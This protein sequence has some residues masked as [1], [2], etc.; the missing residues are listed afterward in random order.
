[1]GQD[2]DVLMGQCVC[3]E[4][5]R[6]RDCS[7][8]ASG[9]FNLQVNNPSG[10]QPCFCSG[11]DITCSAAPGYIAANISTEFSSEALDL[12]GWRV[13]TTNLSVHPFPDSVVTTMPFSNGVTITP[14]SAAYLQ[15]P[16][17][18]LGNRL[19]SYLQFITISLESLSVTVI[20][21]TTTQFDIIVAGNNL[22]LGAQFPTGSIT[23]VN[24]QIQLHESF[25]W[26]HIG[27]NQ[28]ASAN[29][30][31]TVLSSL[32]QLYIT[33]S[34]NSSIILSSIQLDT[35]QIT[36]VDDPAT[37]TWVEQCNCP[38]GYSGLSCQQCSPGYT[39]SSS[40]SCELCQCNGF[41]ETCN[42]DT[43]ECIEC[44]GSTTGDSCEQCLPGTYGDPIQGIPCLPC[45]CPLTSTP[46]QFTEEC[47]LQQPNTIICLNCPTGHIGDHCE[48]CSEGYFGDPTGD[49]GIPTGCS[50]C[51]CNGNINS[52][53][54]GNCNVT[55]GVCLQCI[56]N[57][58][59]NMCERCANGYFGDAIIAK[60]CSGTVCYS[61]VITCI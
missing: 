27:S 1:M 53:L 3:K 28:A 36:N 38:I 41:S 7:E 56:N 19:S 25:E 8:C 35:V 18:Y 44:R 12:R 4:N 14:N 2:C 55:T 50:D 16:Q 24:L 42:I 23:N 6:T 37:V 61:F 43:G 45:P 49:T 20:V 52:N 33:A 26:Y 17:Q 11:M 5:T 59:G 48:S 10:C 57:T 60:N 32:E 15:A 54:P 29:D 31:Q 39:R 30:M 40:G 21:E 47:I 9:T 22:E 51:L 46:G 58:A 34:F 13:L